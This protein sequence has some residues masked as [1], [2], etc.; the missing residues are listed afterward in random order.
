M[1]PRRA[2]QLRLRGQVGAKASV[3]VSA[4]QAAAA[5][6]QGYASTGATQQAGQAASIK[7]RKERAKEIKPRAEETKKS[8]RPIASLRLYPHH[9]C[10]INS[11]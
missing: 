3:T 1:A 7:R 10:V 6:R 2:Q 5:G 11:F 9:V 4:G 8:E